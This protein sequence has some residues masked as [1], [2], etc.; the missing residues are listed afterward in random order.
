M[1]SNSKAGHVGYTGAFCLLDKISKLPYC[2]GPAASIKD[3]RLLHDAAAPAP[4]S[5]P[6]PTPAFAVSSAP[7]TATLRTN[8]PPVNK[9]PLTLI[10]LNTF[11]HQLT[12]QHRHRGYSTR[13]S[14]QE[15]T[16]ASRRSSPH[17]YGRY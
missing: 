16:D 10:N 3:L 6:N 4:R 14:T 1:F 11:K 8:T 12:L 9:Q 5:A 13:S 15:T 2:P 17:I 7:A